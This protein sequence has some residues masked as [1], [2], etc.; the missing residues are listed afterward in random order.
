VTALEELV[1]A[2]GE[3]GAFFTPAYLAQAKAYVE[4][5]RIRAVIDLFDSFALFAAIFTFGL[6][7]RLYSWAEGA[8]ETLLQRAP[9]G[10]LAEKL[11]QLG[12]LIFRGPGLGTAALFIVATELLFIAIDLPQSLYFDYVR[13]RREGLT[14]YTLGSW[15][16]DALKGTVASIFGLAL[17]FLALYALMRWLPRRWGLV[18]GAV[19]A[20]GMLVAATFDPYR[21]LLVTLKPLPEG[22]VR[23]EVIATLTRAGVS[24]RNVVVEDTSRTSR[25]A[26][27]YFAGQGP[28]RTVVL[29]DTLLGRYSPRELSAVVAH[30]AGHVNESLWPARLASAVALLLGMVGLQVLLGALARRGW[31]GLRAADDVVGYLVIF[32]L[33]QLL[34]TIAGPVAAWRSRL[35]ESD[36]DAFA[37]RLTRD[38]AA[39]ASMMAKLTAQNRA[40]PVPPRWSELWRAGHPPAARR[41]AMALRFASDQGLPVPLPPPQDASALEAPA[42]L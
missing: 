33:F 1:A 5:L 23:A 30:E 22:P 18:L 36:A 2:G 20:V 15:S 31:F 39:F 12:R 19:G 7:R 4:P 11:N 24:F 27:A 25:R 38:P 13:E 40:D 3:L 10:G 14:N 35:R 9:P 41:L 28:T 29:S 17:C 6:H 34:T 16:R 26:D 21:N 42:P 37:L 32:F 8:A